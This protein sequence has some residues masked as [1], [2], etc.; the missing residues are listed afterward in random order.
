[1]E[2]KLKNVSKDYGSVLAV[3]NVNYSMET[4]VYGLLGVNGAGKTT[5]MTMLCTVTCPS[6]GGI[7]WDGDDIFE[8]EEDYRGLLGYL[9]QDFGYYPDLSV[10]DYLMSSFSSSFSPSPPPTS[11]PCLLL[12][13]PFLQNK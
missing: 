3:D 10:F 8:L 11:S 12:V 4:G 1:M 7:T 6:A 9:P 5:L 13:L 2:L